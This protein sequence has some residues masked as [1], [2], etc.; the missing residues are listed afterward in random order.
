[1]TQIYRLRSRSS[2]SSQ[3]FISD[4][5]DVKFI[6]ALEAKLEADA[7]EPIEVDS[8]GNGIYSVWKGMKVIGLI[9]RC[10]RSRFWIAEPAGKYNPRRYLSSELAVSAV[11]RVWE[12]A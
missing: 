7:E 11:V 5:D 10:P 9:K 4:D 8:T 6:M 1:M 2:Y 3:I 12:G